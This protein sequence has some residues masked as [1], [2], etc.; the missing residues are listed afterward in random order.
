[1]TIGNQI[2]GVIQAKG[3]EVFVPS[4]IDID[5]FLPS[6]KTFYRYIG[7]LTTPKCSEHVLWT[8][9]ESKISVCNQIVINIKLIAFESLIFKILD[10]RHKEHS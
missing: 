9:F 5:E 8:I 3:D 1:M 10:R 6:S 7:S 2:L 4:H